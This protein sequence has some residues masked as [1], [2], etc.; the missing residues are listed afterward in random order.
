MTKMSESTIKPRPTLENRAD[1]KEYL[2]NTLYETTIIK[3]TASWCG[4][5]K[6]IAPYVQ[7]MNQEYSKIHSFE[8]IELDVD[9][10]LDLYAFFKKMK[11]ANGVPTFLCFKKRLFDPD[12]YYVPYQCITGADPRG[13]QN[14]YQASFS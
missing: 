13:L 12:H 4:P 14:F 3:L 9:E 6:K 11:M 2:S 10:C 8:Y 1:L 7:Q 5:C